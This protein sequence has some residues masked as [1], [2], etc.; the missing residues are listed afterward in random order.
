M[1]DAARRAAADAGCLQ[2]LAEIESISI[3]QGLWQ[4]RNPGAL[5]AAEIGCP[6]A[7]Q[8]VSDLGVLQLT[9]FH[10]LCRRIAA[11]EESVGL[12]VGG[13]AKYRDLRARIAGVAAPET[14][15]PEDTPAPDVRLGSND[16]FCSDLES[17]RGLQSPI[18]LFAIIESALRFAHGRT[19]DEH[20]DAVARLYSEFSEIAAANP[21]AWSREPMTPE[22]IRDAS[23]KNAMQ[24]YPYTK[25]HCSQW[26]VNRAV[27]LLV[28]S[29]RRAEDLGIPREK[30][31]FPLA[32]A[33]SHHVVVLAQ[34]RHLHSHPGTAV[35]GARALTL[36]GVDVGEL[37][38]T[39]LY[40]CFPAAVGSFAFDLGVEDG[41][42]LS[43]TG[44]MPFSGGPFNHFALESVGRMVEVLREESSARRAG[45]VANLSGIFGKQGVMV[46]ANQPRPSGFAF[47]D[48]T[49]EVAAKDEPVRL[50]PEYIGPA[51]IAGYT[52][53]YAKGEVSHGVAI[54]DVPDGRRTVARSDD[55]ALLEEMMRTEYCGRTV[56]VAEDGSFRVEA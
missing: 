1:V 10:N 55:R 29:A 41:T 5:V 48:V 45:L 22:V 7:R 50:A 26:N 38:A 46:L 23:D 54:C 2:L 25:L 56:E 42:P 20:R 13:E 17:Q 44:A 19:V 24:A 27:A 6:Q 3:P 30:W 8:I 35:A 28:C 51:E 11:G 15:Q 14:Q 53:V 36:A 52:V 9:P 34:Q 16:P 21:H 4:Y 12:V 47:V 32:A 40:S 37:V 33:E 49:D 43:V 31:I 39:D 18:A